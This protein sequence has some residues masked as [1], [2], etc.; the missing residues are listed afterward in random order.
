VAP[1]PSYGQ[2]A[3]R[4]PNRR[5]P[6]RGG[7]RPPRAVR[8][9][10][11]APPRAARGRERW[12]LAGGHRLRD[13]VRIV[14]AR[15]PVVKTKKRLLG[16]I[17]AEDDAPELQGKLVRRLW[18]SV[19]LACAPR[20]RGWRR[21]SSVWPSRKKHQPVANGDAYSRHYALEHAGMAGMAH[22][23]GMQQSAAAP[24]AVRP[25]NRVGCGCR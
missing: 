19:C 7:A 12:V 10:S 18:T 6:R 21:D 24:E 5:C 9:V 4:P 8:H 22:M 11:A 2:A 16:A 15:L 23:A 20:R 17:V 1:S 25:A 3:H 13:G 14:I